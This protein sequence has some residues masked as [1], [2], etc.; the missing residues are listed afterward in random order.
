MTTD[1]LE[2]AAAPRKLGSASWFRLLVRGVLAIAGLRMVSVASDRM[3]SFVRNEANTF[4]LDAGLWWQYAGALV[5]A[6]VLFGLACSMP[7][8]TVR[9]APSRLALAALAMAPT[10]HFW[11]VW[12]VAGH[13]HIYWID[14]TIPQAVFPVLAGVALAACLQRRDTVGDLAA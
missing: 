1:Q 10:I 2:M 4:Q 14:G 11:W 12:M 7:F 8:H 6:G 3:E 13:G 5:L 9:F